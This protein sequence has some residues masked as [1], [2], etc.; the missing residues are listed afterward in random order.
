[1]L[2]RVA[3]RLGIFVLSLLVASVLVFAVMNVLPGDPARIAAGLN[4][5]D[6]SV[7]ALQKQFG[8]DRPLPVQYFS[9]LGGLLT[10]DFGTSYITKSDL[11][12]EIL[13]KLQVTLWVVGAGMVVALVIAVPLG[14]VMAVRHRKASGVALSA[15]S[16]IGVS[17]PAFALALIL[18]TFFSVK[19][20]WLPFGVWTPPNEDVGKFLAGLVLPALS[21]GVVQGAVL[22]RYVRSAILDV[23]RQDYIR[24]ARAKGLTP[25]GALR[26]HAMRNAAI[27]VVT[28]LGLQLSTL[29]VGAVVIERVF[30]L[31]GLGA[32][33]LDKVGQRDLIAVQS[34][35]ML[36]VAATLIITVVVDLLYAAIDPRL[37][38]NR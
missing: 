36:L 14:M 1:M 24:T 8:L 16:Q 22:S 37:R 13:D 6:A 7:A 23:M 26:R 34:I 27:P 12:A 31:P 4:A 32:M 18:I 19:N 29:L 35:V 33:L 9:W 28:V 25:Y 20:N 30:V 3:S 15:V 5:S 21:L 17:I 11:T 38:S 10:G 2:I